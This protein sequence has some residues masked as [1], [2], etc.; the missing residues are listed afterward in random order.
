MVLCGGWGRGAT[1]SGTSWSAILLV[2]L[3]WFFFCSGASYGRDTLLRFVHRKI[4]LLLRGYVMWDSAVINKEFHKLQCWQRHPELGKEGV[5]VYR[6]D[7]YF[8]DKNGRSLPEWK[9]PASAFRSP[10]EWFHVRG[11]VLTFALGSLAFAWSMAALYLCP[12]SKDQGVW[13][14]QELGLIKFWKWGLI[15]RG[16]WEDAA[17]LVKQ[18]SKKKSFKVSKSFVEPL[19]NTRKYMEEK[20]IRVVP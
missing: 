2:L 18:L 4:I 5:F 14:T 9:I 8:C 16:C 13:A 6:I 3:R 15:V 1:R 7:T 19:E 20:K 11:S 12:V 17:S 10:R